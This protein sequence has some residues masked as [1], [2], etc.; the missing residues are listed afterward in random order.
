MAEGEAPKVVD[1]L[2]FV[3]LVHAALDET[4]GR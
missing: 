4:P 2:E 1:M 3:G